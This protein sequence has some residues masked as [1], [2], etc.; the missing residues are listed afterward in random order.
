MKQK[1][2]NNVPKR[3]RRNI[4]FIAIVTVVLL[5]VSSVMEDIAYYSSSAP[6]ALPEYT[7]QELWE[8]PLPAPEWISEISTIYGENGVFHDK[9]LCVSLNLSSLWDW[10]RGDHSQILRRTTGITI[11]GTKVSRRDMS[12]WK[13][14]RMQLN[15][16]K[17]NID[18]SLPPKLVPK[19][20]G[21]FN[22][23]K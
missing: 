23:Y 5:V 8:N 3:I 7:A 22:E 9:S 18:V 16:E 15:C 13:I 19:Q 14:E 21:V 2:K 12:F 10:E 17:C 11:D 1:K 6:I 20:V 4:F